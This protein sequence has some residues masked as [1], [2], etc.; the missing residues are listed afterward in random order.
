MGCVPTIPRMDRNGISPLNYLYKQYTSCLIPAF[1]LGI[2]NLGICKDAAAYTSAPNRNPEHFISPEPLKLDPCHIYCHNLLLETNHLLCD[3][4]ETEP[5]AFKPASP[6][7]CLFLL[8][9]FSPHLFAVRSRSCESYSH[10]NLWCSNKTSGGLRLPP[11]NLPLPLRAAT[12]HLGACHVKIADAASD[13]IHHRKPFLDFNFS[14]F[15]L[16]WSWRK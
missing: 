15:S 5:L 9:L 7:F 16:S 12:Q 8:L 3:Y 10:W 11:K 13:S 2:W 6:A 1:H 14:V 4:V